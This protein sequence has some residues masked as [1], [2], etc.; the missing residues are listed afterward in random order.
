MSG[1]NIRLLTFRRPSEIPHGHCQ[2]GCGE[3]TRIAPHTDRP[4]R[5]LAGEPVPFINH[6]GKR[7]A[8][9]VSDPCPETG[10]MEWLGAVTGD[11]YGRYNAQR[12]HITVY[13]QERDGVPTGMQLD[14]LCRNKM[15]VNPAHLEVVTPAENT[16][17]GTVAKL[18]VE[19]VAKIRGLFAGG[20]LTKVEIGKRFGVSGRHV[21]AIVRGDAW[22]QP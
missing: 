4:R 15:C 8:Q 16:R 19:Q 20:A 3:K 10:C 2:C 12:A 17:R 6:H 18:S 9:Y 7:L 13:E 14:H 1:P 11:G 22:G 21:T 5:W